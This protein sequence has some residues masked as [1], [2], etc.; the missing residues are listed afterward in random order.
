[1]S[2]F[3]KRDLL[4]ALCLATTVQVFAQSSDTST[5]SN[6]TSNGGATNS[7]PPA[8]SPPPATTAPTA[9][10]ATRAAQTIQT[11]PTTPA[12]PST[13]VAP[14]VTTPQNSQNQPAPS[15]GER[16]TICK[17][18]LNRKKPEEKEET[19]PAN[20]EVEKRRVEYLKE[21]IRKEPTN[22]TL[23][24]GL[25]KEFYRQGDYEKAGLLM[26]KQIEKLEPR[27]M[28]FL[29]QVHIKAKQPNEVRK[30]AE[31]MIGRD[32]KSSMAYYYLAMGYNPRS[33]KE[34]ESY[35]T[36]LLKAVELDPK[37]REAIDTLANFFY[38]QGNLFEVRSLYA[39]SLKI[40]KKDPELTSKLCE[41]A[42]MDSLHDETKTVCSEAMKVAPTTPENYVY[43]GISLKE[44]EKWEEAHKWFESATGKFPES[45]F[46]WICLAETRQHKKDYVGVYEAYHAAVQAD[47]SSERALLGLAVSAADIKKLS[48]SLETFKKLCRINRRYGMNLKKVIMDISK[49]SQK[50]DVMQFDAVL[51]KC[52]GYY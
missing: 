48:E 1:M 6:T 9:D 10:E 28:M 43:M 47:P 52:G 17:R 33:P 38:D 36:N 2:A 21:K 46:A 51:R 39:D 16:D 42:S 41:A 34:K 23:I 26:W 32:P 44:Q 25:A 11:N 35:K 45:E 7:T 31:V 50:S 8:S 3:S 40:M 18:S 24:V 5:Q 12:A 49:S 30:V 27:D 19:K 4:L 15:Y 13:P 20:G 37:N 14:G 29:A 22:L